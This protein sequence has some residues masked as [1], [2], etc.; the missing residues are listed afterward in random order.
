MTKSRLQ[1]GKFEGKSL[2]HVLTDIFK[3]GHLF[4][5]LL[6][7]LTR[8]FIANGT[9]MVVYTRVETELKQRWGKD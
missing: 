4:Q 9:S 6:P 1:S 5:G 2:I 8:S 7:G 3:A